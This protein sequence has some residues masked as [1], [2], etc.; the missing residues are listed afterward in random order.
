[1]SAGSAPI[2]INDLM[3][4]MLDSVERFAPQP[5]TSSS[6][7]SMELAVSSSCVPE[8]HLTADCWCRIINQEAM[9]L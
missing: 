2:D 4:V 3:F 7:L 1:M 6:A 9:F 5:S 8:V